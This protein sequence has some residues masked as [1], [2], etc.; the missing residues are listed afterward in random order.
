MGAMTEVL[1]YLLQTVLGLLLLLVL[2]RLLLQQARADFYNPISQFVA[3]VTNPLLK[4][5]QKAAPGLWGVVVL[6]L[7]LQ[8]LSIASILLLGGYSL[9]NPLIML[10][11]AFL[12]L[13]GLLVNFYFFAILAMIILS[14]IAPGS[15]NPAV[16]LLHQLT[17]PVMAPCRRLL[18]SAC[19]NHRAS[20][21][22][23]S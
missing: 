14:W 13:V 19:G 21:C 23:L 1:N 20:C 3:K 12:G 6:L 4:P 15:G 22:A 18:P 10:V 7:L 5:L 11:W 16:Y 8:I 17:E 9:P 2:L